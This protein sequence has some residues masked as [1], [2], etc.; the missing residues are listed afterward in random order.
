M[1]KLLF[2]FVLAISGI[3]GY[4]QG[5][6]L[7][8]MDFVPQSMRSNPAQIQQSNFHFSVLPIL[9]NIDMSYINNGFVISDILDGKT[10]ADTTILTPEKMVGAINDK[11]FLSTKV[12]LDFL[13]F[14]FKV[15][16]K[17]YFSFN[18]SQFL[19]AMCYRILNDIFDCLN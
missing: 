5:L 18:V 7:Y 14:G 16:E 8:N 6:T 4:A 1:K 19:P 10:N 17:H 15:K 13:S 11:N 3:C 2:T 12:N 9:P